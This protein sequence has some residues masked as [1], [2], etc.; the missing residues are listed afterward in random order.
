MNYSILITLIQLP[1]SQKSKEM[2]YS[3]SIGTRED[4]LTERYNRTGLT[5]LDF[6]PQLYINGFTYPELPIIKQENQSVFEGSYLGF[7]PNHIKSD[8]AAIDFRKKYLTLNAKA[9]TIFQLPTFKGSIMTRRCLIP[10]T[11]FFEWRDLNKAKYPYYITLKKQD[12]FSFAGIYNSYKNENGE[13]KSTF[14]IITTEAN[15]LM[16]QV[17]NLK[18]RMPLIFT[19]ETEN[20]WLLDALTESDVKELMQQLDQKLMNA[21]PIAKID[22]RKAVADDKTIIEEVE[23]VELDSL[24]I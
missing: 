8:N 15:P 20:D 10:A 24:V 18:K 6:K 21:H 11:G 22:P 19:K 1:L 16:A 2:C 23:Y 4:R 17:H 12:V 7:I 3:I 5:K 9:E 13:V 14:A